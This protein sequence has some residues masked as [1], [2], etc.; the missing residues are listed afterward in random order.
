MKEVE[1]KTLLVRE[2]GA[3]HKLG[4][5]YTLINRGP[6][7][8]PW[9]DESGDAGF[10]AACREAI[11][12]RPLLEQQDY[13]NFLG[14][15]RMKWHDGRSWPGGKIGGTTS[16]WVW[17]KG[18]CF[19][20]RADGTLVGLSKLGY[21]NLSADEGE[22]WSMPLVPEGIVANSGKVWAQRTPDGRYAMLYSPQLKDRWPMVVTTSKD[23][24]TFGDMRVVH[25][26]VPPQRYA[27]KS[28]GMGP[29]Y[30]RGVA[31]WAG[32]RPTID[33]AAIF[34]IY[35]VNKEDI[36][37]SRIPVPI[38]PEG[39]VAVDDSFDGSSVGPRVPGWNT[40][41][42][43][44]AP[45]RIAAEG[46]NRFLELRDGEPV[47]HARAIRT[48]SPRPS[49]E[50]S[51]KIAAAQADL[52]RLE[53]ELLDTRGGRPVRIVLDEQGRVVVGADDAA[54]VG[55]YRAGEWTTFTLQ[56]GNGRFSLKRDGR[57]LVKGAP[58]A[59]EQGP[60]YA[61][62]FRTGKFRGAVSPKATEDLPDAEDPV[63][64]TVYRVDDVQIRSAD[65]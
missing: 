60:F 38:R 47:D 63:P 55:R 3:D 53:I 44:W 20:H 65:L 58:I 37:I 61:L 50:A 7:H 45:V 13:G 4:A 8:P 23:G 22:T 6:A 27:G 10:I 1:K 49:V 29:Q 14:E 12:H 39:D 48:F 40:Y 46:G 59:G 57:T 28:K 30:L 36:W 24:I 54:P 17:G 34:A 16:F 31:E 35:S 19:F 56:A 51:F 15:R 42:P 62:S 41:A 26:E 52:G 2:I 32:D 21:V 25:G 11:G 64:E 18:M 5:V 43:T 33:P 9:F